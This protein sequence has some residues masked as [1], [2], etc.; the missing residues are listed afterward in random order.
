MTQ[1]RSR[2]ATALA[3]GPTTTS[4]LP[5]GSQPPDPRSSGP[6]P[7]AGPWA[8]RLRAARSWFAQGLRRLRDCVD[9]VAEAGLAVTVAWLLGVY[10]IG[11][12]LPFFAPAAAL[13]VLGV[14]RGQRLR[15][16]LDIWVGVAVG[17]LVAD[18]IS[19]AIG[20]ASVWSVV[21]V[22]VLTLSVAA[23]L[24]GGAILVVQSAVSAIYVAVT[25]P[26][27]GGLVPARFF[28]ALVGGAVAI[29]VNQLPLRTDPLTELADESAPVF[30]RLAD[31]LDSVAAALKADDH[32][33][34]RRALEEARS[35]DSAVAAFHGAVAVAE[36]TTRF[37]ILRR[38]RS[39]SLAA[40]GEVATKMDHAVR[41]VRVLARSAV[42]LLRLGA[43]APPVLVDAVSQLAEAV[44]ALGGY[45]TALVEEQA[46]AYRGRGART[47]ARTTAHPV[48][49]ARA[50]A[51]RSAMR[52]VRLAAR[53]LAPEQ[54]LPAVVIVG[55]VRSAAV[56]LL[57]GM[58][59]DFDEVMHATDEALGFA[60]DS[61]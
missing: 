14:T 32:D 18:V 11:D 6:G 46:G 3:A 39:P 59:L 22:T 31:V 20:P 45:L 25:T 52:A 60:P 58:G 2:P 17:V 16:A 12:D 1:H 53:A 49:D 26:V 4:E 35:I 7:A 61:P 34:A 47:R 48:T 38:R 43:P 21:A 29:A 42:M 8:A 15:R 33:A 13:I 44:R 37:T 28:D 24:G 5:S 41:N 54:T 36:E 30:E 19:H 27:D 50:D 23:F 51:H 55:Q 40:Y 10:L 57:L 9:A 56:D